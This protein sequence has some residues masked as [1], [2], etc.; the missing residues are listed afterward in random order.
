MRTDLTFVFQ[1]LVRRLDLV[2]LQIFLGHVI[3]GNLMRADFLL[4]SV[5]GFFNAHH[6]IGLQ[7]VPFFQQL[8]DTLRSRL[9]DPG[10]SLQISR[11]PA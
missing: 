8:V 9:F 5:P 1:I 7:R 6:G 11:L 2:F 3:L 10:Q 4:V